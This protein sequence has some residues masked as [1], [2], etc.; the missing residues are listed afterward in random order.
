MGR[1]RETYENGRPI[2]ASGALP[3]GPS[4]TTVQG[5]Q[6]GLAEDPR[7]AECAERRVFTY[8]IGREPSCV[9]AAPATNGLKDLVLN[10]LHQ[11]AFAYRRGQAKGDTP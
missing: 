6:A 10:V 8:A 9:S 4:F 2:D 11:P 1:Y 7:V 5:L 3:G